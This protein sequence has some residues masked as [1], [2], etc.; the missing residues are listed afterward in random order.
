MKQSKGLRERLMSYIGL[1]REQ[2]SEENGRRKMIHCGC[3]YL[4]I[5]RNFI[6]NESEMDK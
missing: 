4:R 1:L 5:Y 3:G 2:A 6:I